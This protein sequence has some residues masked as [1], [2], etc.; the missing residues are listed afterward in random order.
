MSDKV[1]I[2]YAS[3]LHARPDQ[4]EPYSGPRV[5]IL[6]DAPPVLAVPYPKPP[7][8]EGKP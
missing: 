3:K 8:N 6:C 4:A 1:T 2:Y 5:L 7:A